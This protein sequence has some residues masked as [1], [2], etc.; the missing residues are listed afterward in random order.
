LAGKIK[1]E[2]GV[3]PTLVASGGGVF[4]VSVDEE[5]IYSKK[6]TGSFPDEEELVKR[7]SKNSG[8]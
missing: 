1:S 6:K 5:L 3:L 7:L 8:A 4:E 2:L